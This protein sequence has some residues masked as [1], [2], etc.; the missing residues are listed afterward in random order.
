M[1][2]VPETVESARELLWRHGSNSRNL[3][4][5]GRVDPGKE[6]PMFEIRG[7][8][9]TALVMIDQIDPATRTQIQDFC[10]AKM[11]AGL[12]I[13]IMPDCHKGAG[14]VIGFTCPVGEYIAPNIVGVDIN[15]GIL[16]VRI[17]SIPGDPD[18]W[19]PEIDTF[20]RS[21]IPIGTGKVNSSPAAD[22]PTGLAE[23][24]RALAKKI[25]IESGYALRSL[26]NLGSG[27]HFIELGKED[28]EHGNGYWLF[29]HTGSR[30]FGLQVANYHTGR[31]KAWSR[32]KPGLDVTDL[33]CLPVDGEGQEYLEDMAVAAA[34]A[35]EN[36]R[37]IAD[38]IVRGFFGLTKPD[39]VVESVHNYLN[40]KD[41]I[42]RKGAISAEPGQELVI[43]L[44]NEDGVI[45]GRGKGNPDWNCSAPHGAGRILS[46]SKAKETLSLEDY[47]Q[48]LAKAGVWSSSVNAS[49][50]E[51]SPRAYKPAQAIIDAIGPTVEI[52]QIV[53]PVYNL[54]GDNQERKRKKA[55]VSAEPTEI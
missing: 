36:R 34:F 38:M 30:N 8:Y 12:Y 45:L 31:A 16:A 50:L 51:E 23:Q 32:G 41:R 3:C 33:Y 2:S 5:N 47:A 24:V 48:R 42:I 40:P 18:V 1:S 28:A 39:R 11:F 20:I 13:A 54:K 29:V 53:R 21:Y 49:T 27:N 15:C 55:S 14:A 43:P 10:N 35:T 7:R 22:I 6:E 44:N 46:R 25:D 19:R 4:W 17:G 37:Q 9:A 26:G 52:E